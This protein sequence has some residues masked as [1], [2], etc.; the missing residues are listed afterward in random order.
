MKPQADPRRART[1]GSEKELQ[2]DSQFRCCV[3]VP[4]HSFSSH[5]NAGQSTTIGNE[6][7]LSGIVSI[8][9]VPRVT[10]FQFLVGKACPE[11]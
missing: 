6:L 9:N 5:D 2:A 7:T 4:K 10:L 11:S 8:G 1:R 3:E